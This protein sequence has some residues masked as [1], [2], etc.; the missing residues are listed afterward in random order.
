M[1]TVLRRASCRAAVEVTGSCFHF[2]FLHLRDVTAR[3]GGFRVG[4][5]FATPTLVHF[6]RGER[7]SPS[8]LQ[9]FP[10]SRRCADRRTAEPPED[11]HF[12]ARLRRRQAS[13][14]TVQHLRLPCAEMRGA[15][16]RVCQWCPGQPGARGLRTSYPAMH[17]KGFCRCDC[18][19]G[20]CRVSKLIRIVIRDS[21]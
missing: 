10:L 3:L 11:A 16:R 9:R 17:H 14:L 19:A 2:R 21:D 5:H 4:K 15:P 18:A 12:S 6:I 7:V 20:C 1:S 8:S 13:L